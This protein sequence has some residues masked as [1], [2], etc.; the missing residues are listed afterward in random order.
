M[1]QTAYALE[2]EVESEHWWF[3]GRR[4][5]LSKLIAQL[6]ISQDAKILDVGTGTGTN[7]RLLQQLGFKR[8]TGLD[9]S[10]DAIHFCKQ[11]GLGIVQQGNACAMPFADES[12]DIIFATDII[13]HIDEDLQALSEIYR[14]L[15]VGGTAIIMVPAFQFLWG[16]QDRISH[17]KR[18]YRRKQLLSQIHTS[19]L[20][21]LKNHYFNYI[22]F[23]PI[24]LA[25]K[26]ID[27]LNL[28][29]E[30]EN[31]VNTKFIN[32]ILTWIFTIDVDT[33]PLLRPPFGVSVLAV[34]KK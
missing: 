12:F 1:D 25:R 30:N 29:V 23:I 7:L 27:L 33:S 24:L 6:E 21:T 11:K 20:V 5:L 16:V 26:I 14:V 3:V 8:V 32:A 18:R 15:K 4:R 17:H 13:E 9:F 28:K 31:Q 2:A 19:G 10:E 22:L 34:A